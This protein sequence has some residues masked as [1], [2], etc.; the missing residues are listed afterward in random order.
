MATAAA[1]IAASTIGSASFAS[2]AAAPGAADTSAAAE[3]A[4]RIAWG[5]CESPTLQ[6]R[7][8]ECGFVTVPLDYS[9]PNGAKAQI[10]VSRIK[11]K[12]PDAQY[13]G[14]M[15]VNPG[16]PG[17]SGLVLSF[18][19]EF[20]P[21]GAG[22]AYDWIGFDPRGVGS[23][24]PALTCDPNYAAGPRPIYE[25]TTP[26]I[27]KAW[28]TKTKGY[29]Q[30][31]G[32]S[33]GSALLSNL[34]TTDTTRDMDR[35]RAALGEKKLNFYGFSYGT[36]LGQVY[37]TMFPDRVRRMVLDSNVDP[38]KVWYQANLDQDVAF[39]VTETAWWAWLAKYD[40]VY[41]LGKT[42]KQ[43]EARWYAERARLAKNPAGGVVG[44]SEW[45][46]IFLYAGYYQLTWLDLAD[47]W[48]TWDATH[49]DPQPLIDE[50]NGDAG[51]GDD[52]GYAMYL[53][54]QCVDA[55]WPRDWSQ[56]RE[57]NWRTYKKAPFL[58]WGNAWFNAPCAFWPV[59]PSRPVDVDGRGVAPILLVGET[60]D[61]ATPFEG[62]IEVRKRFPGSR[63]IGLPGGTS[64]AMSLFGNECL[65][66]QI[67]AYLADGTL[68]A[69][70]PGKGA[71]TTCA[72]LPVPDPTAAA[73]RTAA[74][75]AERTLLDQVLHTGRR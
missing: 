10:A 68:P 62:S 71:D 26:A 40:D 4:A 49:S 39:E 19:G 34:R 12:V 69:R 35:I 50:Y 27:E 30:A 56:W 31:C 2:A 75:S 74:P 42:E 18:L 52:N 21:N 38:R 28:L 47:L 54:V 16:G 36:Y 24:T 11:H 65:D 60:L 45:S 15:L 23:S 57:D 73:L 41:H 67:A 13:Q 3:T 44:A 8:A 48:A 1:L 53:G 70:K 43:V 29:A 66:N 46:D 22:E 58:T 9:R 17:A 72:P 25:P 64:H 32:K 63:L 14:I 7:N 37:A 5:P 6:R 20:V 59:K 33:G 61:A 55:G 51:V